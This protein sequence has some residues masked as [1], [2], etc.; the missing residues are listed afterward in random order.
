MG[1]INVMETRSE[2]EK[3]V[4][5][6]VAWFDTRLAEHTIPDKNRKLFEQSIWKKVYREITESPNGRI[7]LNSIDKPMGILAEA[8]VEAGIPENQFPIHGS[9]L[10]DVE[11]LSFRIN[12]HTYYSG[13]PD[14]G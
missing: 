11:T 8:C 2:I 10:I 3:L 6:A 5:A 9:F 1:K 4:D 13:R 7:Y 12:T 14:L